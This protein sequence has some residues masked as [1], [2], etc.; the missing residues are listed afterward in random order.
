KDALFL[1]KSASA[2]AAGHMLNASGLFASTQPVNADSSASVTTDYH[3]VY[4]DFNLR[5]FTFAPW[6]SNKYLTDGTTQSF[7]VSAAG[8]AGGAA[9]VTINLW[10]L[11]HSDAASPDHAL[12]VAVNGVPA[13]QT[14]WSG[15]NKMTQLTF[16]IA[17][18]VLN[19]GS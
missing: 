8:A 14:L 11:T 15:G 6:F 17:A 7:T 2:T 1:R 16:Q 13:G 4:F 9:S 3:E 18:G 10:S 19:S 12:Q 5:P